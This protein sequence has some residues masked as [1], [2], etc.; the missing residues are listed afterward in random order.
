M[1]YR[2]AYVASSW[3][4]PYQPALVRALRSA[5]MQVYDFR[6][7]APGVTGFAWSEI[8]PDWMDWMP[9]EWREAL[10]HPIAVKG[11]RNDRRGMDNSECCVLVLPSGRSSHMEAAFMAAQGKPVFTLALDHVAPDLMNLLLGPPEHL[12][13]SM[14]DLFDALGIAD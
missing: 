11:Y 14:D 7:P 8:D 2:S 10:R 12:C 13:C 5:G 3:R 4:N 6:N 1:K 9:S